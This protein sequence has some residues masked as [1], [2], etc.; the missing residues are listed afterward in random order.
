MSRLLVGTIV[1]LVALA[2]LVVLARVGGVTVLPR[3]YLAAWLVLVSLPLGALPVL[4]GLEVAGLA[5]IEIAGAL[6]LLLASLPVLALLIAPVLLD[7]PAIYPWPAAVAAPTVTA[8][9]RHWFTPGFFSLRAV[10]Y[11]VVWIALSLFFVRPAPP[12]AHR[13]VA[14]F[15]LLLHL[16]IGTL[17]GYDWF[18]SLDTG[19]VCSAY[20]ILVISAQCAFAITAA[21]LI[22]LGTGRRASLDRRVVLALLVI[23]AVAVFV[24]FAVYLVV[25]SANLPKEIAWYQ[26]RGGD[27][28]GPAFAVAAPIILV[29][30]FLVLLPDWLARFRGVLRAALAALFVVELADLLLLAS[31]GDGFRGA[32]VLLEI[33]IVIVLAGPAALCALVVGGRRQVQHG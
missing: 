26:T 1:W 30:A 13:A 15:G 32:V 18:M 19:F 25:W 21:S 29:V 17:A 12:G 27:A 22:G 20:G 11:L 14:R 6:R 16:V 3:A 5:A 24:Q 7:L 9:A 28:L 10:G 2:A 31:P 4:M 8:L 33:A 23:V